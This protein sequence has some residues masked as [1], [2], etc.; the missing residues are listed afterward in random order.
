M[1]LDKL[2]AQPPSFFAW[3]QLDAQWLSLFDS[4][5]SEIDLSVS[6]LDSFQ[7]GILI[8]LQEF[9]LKFLQGQ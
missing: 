2:T 4:R 3:Q 8:K 9:L 6:S 7:N 5:F 1:A